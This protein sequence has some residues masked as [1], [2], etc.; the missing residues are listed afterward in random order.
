[1]LHFVHLIERRHPGHAPRV[2]ALLATL[3][4]IAGFALMSARH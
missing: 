2:L 4:A 1:M 3:S